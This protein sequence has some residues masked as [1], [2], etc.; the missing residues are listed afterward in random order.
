MAMAAVRAGR[1]RTADLKSGVP[2][3]ADRRYRRC[4]LVST[5]ETGAI[6]ER[7]D[8]QALVTVMR[9]PTVRTIPLCCRCFSYME[10]L[11]GM[12][13]TRGL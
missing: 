3:W 7:V 11:A 2:A 4:G 6:T 12:L 8:N 13:A 5:S 1:S 10:I 9:S